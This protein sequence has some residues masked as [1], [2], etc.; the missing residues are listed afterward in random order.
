MLP[1]VNYFAF[2]LILCLLHVTFVLNLIFFFFFKLS[3]LEKF[4]SVTY[5]KCFPF[6][7]LEIELL[8]RH[9]AQPF[10]VPSETLLKPGEE[11]G[12]VSLLISTLE[13]G[14]FSC[15]IS[16]LPSALCSELSFQWK[17]KTQ[18]SQGTETAWRNALLLARS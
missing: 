12:P 16:H 8:P 3:I 9:T 13:M 10:L 11:E 1:L 6:P 5:S 4:W 17:M 14:L 2:Y 7:S 18:C 15:T